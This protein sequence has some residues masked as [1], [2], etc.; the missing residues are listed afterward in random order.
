VIVGQRVT[1]EVRRSVAFLGSKEIRISCLEFTFFKI[2]DQRRL[3]TQETVVPE[4]KKPGR[5]AVIS[6]EEFLRKCPTQRNSLFSWL[7]ELGEN[8][9]MT[10]NWGARS[11]SLNVD[12]SDTSVRLCSAFLKGT[13]VV[14]CKMMERNSAV[15]KEQLDTLWKEACDSGV[16]RRGKNVRANLV[17]KN[18]LTDQ[19]A[20]QVIAWFSNVAHVIRQ[21]EIREPE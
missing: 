18:R 7:L 14:S 3:L 11:F 4:F 17:A 12:V 19:Q 1:P 10:V 5:H 16:F 8:E 13:V 15:G 20:S 6:K 2:D 9:S 21:H